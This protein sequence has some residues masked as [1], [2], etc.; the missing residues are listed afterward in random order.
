MLEE[1]TKMGGWGMVT[2][3]FNCDVFEY[4]YEHIV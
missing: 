2:D 3:S 1:E 4:L